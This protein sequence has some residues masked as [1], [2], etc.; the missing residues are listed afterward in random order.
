MSKRRLDWLI[1]AVECAADFGA[2]NWLQIW[3]L[4]DNYLE[5]HG[6]PPTQ[7][8]EDELDPAIEV[9]IARRR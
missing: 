9:V 2:K 5:K 6:Q 4:A 3:T 1:E 7:G 8:N